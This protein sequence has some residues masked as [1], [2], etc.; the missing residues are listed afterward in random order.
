MATFQRKAC[1]ALGKKTPNL[2]ASSLVKKTGNTSKEGGEK[3]RH[4][5]PLAHNVRRASQNNSIRTVCLE[6]ILQRC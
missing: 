3:K 5:V 6:L 1:S 4:T 2:S